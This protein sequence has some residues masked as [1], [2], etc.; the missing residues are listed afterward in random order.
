M[1]LMYFL[2]FDFFIKKMQRINFVY[3][4]LVF[5][6]HVLNNVG[7]FD[8]TPLHVIRFMAA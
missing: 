4:L 3:R 8:I 5:F 7:K 6:F 1:D 2:F